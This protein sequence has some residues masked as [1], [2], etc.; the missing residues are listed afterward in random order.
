MEEQNIRNWR[1]VD[2]IIL[3]FL[4]CLLLLSMSIK[5]NLDEINEI[6]S[7]QQRLDTLTI[8]YEQLDKQ[9]HTIDSIVASGLN[10][11]QLD[12]IFS[13]IDVTTD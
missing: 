13:T 5:N 2:V 3:A 6:T 8:R 10:V 9:A 4:F 12:S 7:A 11:N 1:V